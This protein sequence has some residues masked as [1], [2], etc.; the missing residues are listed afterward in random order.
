MRAGKPPRLSPNQQEP[1]GPTHID[2]GPN[3]PN[4]VLRVFERLGGTPQHILRKFGDLQVIHFSLCHGPIGH[5]WRR[6][7]ERSPRQGNRANA[8]QSGVSLFEE[9]PNMSFSLDRRYL[10]TTPEPHG[11]G[12]SG[13]RYV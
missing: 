10:E 5:F 3:N 2:L 6:T 1:A 8:R 12:I 13:V 9:T 7:P 11:R 4:R